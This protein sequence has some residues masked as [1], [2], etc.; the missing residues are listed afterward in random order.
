MIF[1][2]DRILRHL[3]RAGGLKEILKVTENIRVFGAMEW[4]LE[5]AFAPHYSGRIYK[6]TQKNLINNLSR[7]IYHNG[8]LHLHERVFE[9]MACGRPVIMNRTP[10]DDQPFGICSQFDPDEHFVFYDADDIAEVT[11]ALLGD[12]DRRRRIGD[13]ARERCLAGHTW[14]HRA[15]KILGDFL[16][17]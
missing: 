15:E 17:R 3:E 9:A 12:E 7:I 6:P 1:F 10:Y 5:P 4:Q 11:A 13:R 2:E 16:S 8:I 14:R